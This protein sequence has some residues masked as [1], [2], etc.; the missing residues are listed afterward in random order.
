LPRPWASELLTSPPRLLIHTRKPVSRRTYAPS[1]STAKGASESSAR[2]YDS[3]AVATARRYARRRSG[4]ALRGASG[5]GFG[6][7]AAGILLRSGSYNVVEC[8]DCDLL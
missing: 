7:S 1:R 4:T 5:A 2:C 8:R 3:R 6:A